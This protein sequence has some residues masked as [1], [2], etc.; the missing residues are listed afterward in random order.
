MTS[1]DLGRGIGF[2]GGGHMGRALIAALLR[3]GADRARIFVAEAQPATAR[4]LVAD[5][6]ITVVAEAENLPRE[7]DTL[8]LAVKPQD[9]SA[10]V[11]PL[12]AMMQRQQPLVISVAAG[13]T[14][15]QLQQSC[16]AAVPIVRAMPNRPA[17]YGVGATGLFAPPS[18]DANL[19][20]RAAAILQTAGIVVWVED[21]TLMDVVTALSG[22][23]PAY[24]FR[25]A[26]ALA[27]AG[28]AYGLP[29]E[30]AGR[31]ARA[32]LQGAGAMA[33][34]EADLATLRESVTSKG[35]TTAAA[36]AAFTAKDL[37]S[38]VATAVEAAV[39]RGRELASQAA[40]GG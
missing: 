31:L 37:E 27:A 38:V 2:L 6:G 20:S 19:R 17:V 32:T 22:S 16:G 8:V 1:P 40:R 21:E 25:L 18:L 29:A 14:V 34:P 26:E 9:L 15:A 35:G 5:F 4:A 3:A 24:F 23:G 11:Q 7:L 30:T 39:N 10:A 28:E 13:L 12:G 36:L 33:G